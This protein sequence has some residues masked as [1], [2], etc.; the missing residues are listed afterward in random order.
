VHCS[1]YIADSKH[2]LGA[3]SA[4]TNF[5][6]FTGSYIRLG[7]SSH[8]LARA[9]DIV[10]VLIAMRSTPYYYCPGVLRTSGLAAENG[11]WHLAQEGGAFG[12]TALGTRG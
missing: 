10:K 2:E 12:P 4:D 1:A 6:A 3:A 11:A 9:W 8:A 5:G 7:F